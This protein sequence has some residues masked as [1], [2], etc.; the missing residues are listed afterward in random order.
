LLYCSRPDILRLDFALVPA[1]LKTEEDA[2]AV[3]FMD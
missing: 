1:S 2:R 3:N